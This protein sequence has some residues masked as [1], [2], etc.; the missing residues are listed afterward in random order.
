MLGVRRSGALLSL[1]AARCSSAAFVFSPENFVDPK[2]PA[3]LEQID[4]P[5]RVAT[6]ESLKAFGRL[7][8]SSDEVTTQLGNFEIKPWPV[9]GWR[10]LDPGTGDEAGTVEGQF[11]VK[12]VGDFFYGENLAVATENNHYLDGL[13]APPEVASHDDACA[14]GDGNS[15][16]LWMSE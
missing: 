7:I 4:V 15:I 13:A 3:D 1:H 2:L 16:L 8:H 6:D 12:W 11:K 10:Q 9:S 5:L 14:A